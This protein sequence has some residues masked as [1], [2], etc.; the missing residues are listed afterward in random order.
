MT[1][2]TIKTARF[3]FRNLVLL[4]IPV[5]LLAGV[6]VLFLSTGGG[7]NLRS[8]APVEGL[9]VERYVLKPNLIE[10]HVRNTGPQEIKIASII[11]NSAVMPFQVEPSASIQRLGQAV[12]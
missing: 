5:V 9:D 4:L 11:I 10:L 6:I 1:D 12:I 3:S 7:L 8:A 2:S